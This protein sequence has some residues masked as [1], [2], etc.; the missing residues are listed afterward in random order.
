[1]IPLPDEAVIGLVPIGMNPVTKLWEFY[2]LRSA[3]DGKQAATEIEIPTAQGGRF[4]RGEGRDRDRVRAVAWGHGDFG[5][6]EGRPERAVLRSAG[7]SSTRTLHPVTL[8]PFLPG[9]ARAD[10]RAV[11]AAG[12]RSDDIGWDEGALYNGDEIAIGRTHP[13]D[14]MDW[15]TGDRWMTRHG[16]VLPTEAQWEYGARGG[17]T[18]VFWPGQTAG[19]SAGLCQRARPDLVRE[20]SAVG[21]NPRR[22]RMGSAR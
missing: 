9:A 1:L 19:G 12:R 5:V 2:D 21:A 7:P 16:M 13:A 14:S 11:A 3:W 18:T 20:V 17:T 4:D 22:S 15:D 8:A 6:A 10:A